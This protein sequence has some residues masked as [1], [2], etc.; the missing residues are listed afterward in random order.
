MKKINKTTYKNSNKEFEIEVGDSKQPDFKPQLKLKRW[1]NE[2]NFSCRLIDDDSPAT[3][4]ETEDDIKYKK[5][6]FEAHFYEKKSKNKTTEESLSKIYE[7]VGKCNK[8]GAC[9]KYPKCEK[10]LGDGICGDY[11]NR[12]ENCKK[13][14]C[15]TNLYENKLPTC[16]Y[17]LAKKQQQT[18]IKNP[19]GKEIDYF[20]F[21]IILKEKPVS[22][23]IEF[24]IQSK[25]L[26]FFYQPEL[27]DE[28]LNAG[29]F[30]PLNV[31]GSYAVYHKTKKNNIIGGKEYKSGKAFHIFRPKMFDSDGNYSWGDLNIDEKKGIMSVVIP[32]EFLDTAV[33]PIR[34]ATGLTFGYETAG[35]SATTLEDNIVGSVFTGAAGTGT[36]ITMYVFIQGTNSKCAIYTHSSLAL[37]TNGTTDQLSPSTTDWVTYDFTASPTLTAVDY[38]LVGWGQFAKYTTSQIYYDS[39]DTDQGHVD[40]ETYG[41]FPDP[42]VPSHNNNKY[43]IYCTYTSEA[44]GTNMQIN[45]GDTWK[46]VSAAQINIGDTWKSVAG[47]QINIGDSWKEVF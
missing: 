9:C 34:H 17:S 18:K 31:V 32:Q 36:S 24:T 5:N 45:I 14:P 8:C 23:K 11:E 42:L 39:G 47:A 13:Y 46:E 37:L 29:V 4:E 3:I 21:E 12:P 2:C 1:D 35:A 6:K 19:T 15:L 20:E 43:S 16:G 44:V 30:R 27:T 7:R 38:I 40:S 10:Y 33:Y 22:N 28:E 41:T 26:D 25:G